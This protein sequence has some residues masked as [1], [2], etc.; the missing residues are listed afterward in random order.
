[1]PAA[2][3]FGSRA[4]RSRSRHAR[5]SSPSR[6]R[7]AKRGPATSRATCSSRAR[8]ARAPSTT[9]TARDCASR[10]AGFAPPSAIPP[11]SAPRSEGSRSCRTA[12]T[13]CWC[14][15]GPSIEEHAS[16]LALLNDGEAWSTSALALALGAEPAHA[17]ARAGGARTGR[18]GA[19]LRSRPGAPL[20]HAARS[21]DS[22]QHCYSP[23]RCRSSKLTSCA[24]PLPKSF[25]STARFRGRTTSAASRTTV[26]SVWF[27]AGDSMRVIR[28]RDG[29]RGCA[30]IDVPAHAGTAFDGEFLYQIA[31]G[32]NPEDRSEDRARR[33][34]D[35]GAQRRRQFGTGVG[36]RDALGG[37]VSRRERFIRSIRRPARFFARSSRT[38]SS[39]A[40]RGWR[41]SCGTAPGRATR[42][43]FGESIRTPAQFSK[44]W[45][46]P[47]ASRSRDSSPTGRIDSTAA[48]EPPGS[49]GGAP[50][51][52]G[53]PVIEK[54]RSEALIARLRHAAKPLA[55]PADLD[56]LL[57]AI[58][59]ARFVLLGEAIPRNVGVLYLARRDLQA[60]HSREGLLVHRGRGRLAGLLSREP[61]RESDARRRAQRRERSPRLRALAHVDVGEPRS[62]R[63]RG[64]AARAQPPRSRRNSRSACTVWTC[65]RSGSRWRRDRVSRARGPAGGAH[66]PA[67]LRLLRALRRGCAGVRSGHGARSD[68]PARTRPSRAA[69]AARTG[70]GVSR[71]T[72]ET[73]F[74]MPSRTRSSRGTPSGI[75]ER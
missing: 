53:R 40:S 3:P 60:A 9:R 48:V 51:A 6:A 20:D 47:L 66:R 39:R 56:P 7:S 1:M 44:R 54:D 33:V 11:T 35:S 72:G 55:T 37:G 74:S 28:P 22:R 24:N 49:A 36:R 12:R 27:A 14:W 67:R 19:A 70:T 71:K 59:D 41:E 25:A 34:D 45:S 65:T 23:P 31:E 26:E 38:A 52:K 32:A 16:L 21:R 4:R 2:T 5:C 57:D 75:T 15:R 62:R 42:A 68:R 73:P 58:G 64:V 61:I 18:K 43:S 30:P 69:R 46:C 10:S 50:A 13:R 63:S 17:P 29:R 8:S